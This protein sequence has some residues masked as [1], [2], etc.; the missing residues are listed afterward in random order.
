MT[1]EEKQ[2]IPKG[3]K[4]TELGIIPEDW[5]AVKAGD[6][7]KFQSGNG[8][9]LRFQGTKVEKY[10]FY[11]VSDMNNDENEIFMSNSNNWISDKVR[12]KI[13]A[14]I[15]PKN[16]IV[17]AKI[18]AAIFLERKRI[19]TINSCIDN[20]MTS[21]IHNH[22]RCY[23]R[24]VY[25]VFI[26]K[27]FGDL[28]NT[29]AL[30][31]LSERD[32]AQLNFFLPPYPEQTAIATVLSDIDEL[33]GSLD[34]LIDKKK[35]IKQGV[36]Q[37]LLTGKRRLPGFSG[38]WEAKKLREVVENTVGGD[39]G[40]EQDIDNS[41][42]TYVLRGTD[43]GNA[44][45]GDF[46]TIPIRYLKINS[47]EKRKL[48]YN[49]ILI[50]LS[51]GSNEQPTGRIYIHLLREPKNVSFSNFVKKLF[52]N[53]SLVEPEFFFYYWTLLYIQRKIM[54]YEKRTTGIRNFKYRDFLDNEFIL[55]PP[56]EE[57]TAI[58]AVLSDIDAEIEAL[59]QKR[60]KYKQ[61]K[62]G[63]MQVLLTGKIRLI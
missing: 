58:A 21:F 20:N 43:F 28:V 32:L 45:K 7:G 63:A 10:P 15:V 56:L 27:K 42:S 48:E 41:I 2:I 1:M 30:P 13:C 44:L 16:S 12:K 24:F 33:I 25:Y 60:D 57:Q 40:L 47:F 18:G 55:L 50:E 51:G 35:L 23:Y 3:Y 49:D 4:K 59:E 8:F 39:W 26:S 52:I 53:K 22:S 14:N 5:F 29:T 54:K 6:I 46:R 17:F 61:I 9:P 19:I 34:K 38:N 36:M 37:E 11:K 62:Q 31:S